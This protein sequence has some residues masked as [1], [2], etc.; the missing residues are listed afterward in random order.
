MD[1]TT[2]PR[3]A[4]TPAARCHP[5]GAREGVG[6]G[7][8]GGNAGPCRMEPI[9]AASSAEVWRAFASF[10]RQEEARMMVERGGIGLAIAVPR[11]GGGQGNG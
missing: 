7:I 4:P 9:R 10:L 6:S 5:D 11:Q 8:S 2:S 1:D 3:G